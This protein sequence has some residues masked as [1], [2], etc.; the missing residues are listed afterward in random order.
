ME[1]I[2]IIMS[3]TFSLQIQCRKLFLVFGYVKYQ[4]N[5]FITVLFLSEQNEEKEQTET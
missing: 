1:L 3:T 5:S 2:Q 4:T